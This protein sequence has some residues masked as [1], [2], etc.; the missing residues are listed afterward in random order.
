MSTPDPLGAIEAYG[1]DLE[2]FEEYNCVPIRAR[3]VRDLLKVRTENGSRVLKKVSHQAVPLDWSF[4]CAEYVAKSG[5]PNVPR[6]VR[7]RYGDPYVL[8]PTGTYYMTA[9]WPGRELDVQ[10]T[11]EL[12]EGMQILGEWHEAAFG[13]RP[14][15]VEVPRKAPFLMRLRRAAEGLQRYRQT[16]QSSQVP[17]PFQRLFVANAQD[18]LE[19]L[20][21]ALQRLEDADFT[22]VDE[23]AREEGWMCHGDYTH[24]NVTVDGSTYT[25]WNYDKVHPGLPLMDTALYLHRYMPAYN[26]DPVVLASAVEHY[27]E[28]SNYPENKKILAALLA[29]P[30]RSMQVVSWYFRRSRDWAEEDFVGALQSSLDMDV[31]RMFGVQEVFEDSCEI[32]VQTLAGPDGNQEGPVLAQGRQVPSKSSVADKASVDDSRSAASIRKRS[33]RPLPPRAK[34]AR[35]KRRT[36]SSAAAHRPRLW[37]D[38]TPTD[39]R[40]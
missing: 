7:T 20:L 39:D 38:A 2:V 26:W 29:V 6:F 23:A 35:A 4:F 17:T 11:T 40:E 14:Q 8:H 36:L 13:C 21:G 27:R 19:R 34:N 1:A 18:L 32:P 28:T 10:K 15:G 33:K 30:L 5:F 9:W 31:Q 24:H 12:F 37:G 22:T 16:S 25:A 3:V